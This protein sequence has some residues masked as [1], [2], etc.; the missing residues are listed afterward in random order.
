[1]LSAADLDTSYAPQAMI[2]MSVLLILGVFVKVLT[3]WRK[4]LVSEL[5]P[6]APHQN[7]GVHCGAAPNQDISPD[8]DVGL[9]AATP[10]QDVRRYELVAPN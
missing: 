6:A 5:Q 4:R 10:Y 8:Q 2:V 3:L 9:N 1:M 7:I